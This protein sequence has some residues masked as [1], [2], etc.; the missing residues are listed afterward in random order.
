[1]LGVKEGHG[2]TE[3]TVDAADVAK[4]A[5]LRYVIDAQPGIRRVRVGDGFDYVGVDGQPVRGE[6]E[7]QRIKGLGIP[8]AWE[9]VWIAPTPRG[10]IQATGRD[11]KGRKQYRYHPHWREVRDET[12]YNRMILFGETLPM[13]RKWIKQDLARRDLAREKVLAAV[14]ELLDETHIRIGNEEYA[15]ENESFGLTTLRDEHVDVEGSRIHFAFRGKSGKDH[16]VDVRDRRVANV[17]KKMH[18]I[19]GHELFHYLDHTGA[20]HAIESDDVN[21]YLHEITGQH[22]TAKDFRTWVGTVTAAH[23]LKSTGPAESE[24]QAKHNVVEAVT[25]AAKEL[26]NTPAICRKSYVHPGIISSYIDGTMFVS[27]ELQA[28]REQAESRD[29][30]HPE[31]AEVLA[32][33]RGLSGQDGSEQK[34]GAA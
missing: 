28:E 1:M 23:A 15:R 12:K 32:L 19:P 14:V 26:G 18:D 6:K 20:R 3:E 21:R 30:L 17:I 13:I 8:P 16:V 11:A 7:L 29:G 10:H 4:A 33:L 5:G 9:N 22:F 24:S 25:W 2:P 27:P 34:V 31:E